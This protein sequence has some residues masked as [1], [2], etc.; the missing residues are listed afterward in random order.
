MALLSFLLLFSLL[1][2]ASAAIFDLSELSW[3][4]RNENGSIVIP[5]RV[6]SQAHLD[7][8][9]ANIITEPVLEINDFTQRWV[10]ISLSIPLIQNTDDT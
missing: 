1:R 9:S 6:P 7:L 10:R 5:G 3:T 8:L 4:L 2:Y